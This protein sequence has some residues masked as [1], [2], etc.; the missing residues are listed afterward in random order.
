MGNGNVVKSLAFFLAISIVSIGA[1]E[2]AGA[3]VQVQDEVGNVPASQ[4][5]GLRY[6]VD[7]ARNRVWFLTRDGVFVYEASKPEKVLVQL[8]GWQWVDVEYGCLPDLALGPSGEAIIT[9]NIVPTLWRVDPD[10]LV[11][12]V[13]PLEL[14][15][16]TS[17]DVGFSGL[18]YSSR[19]R[20]FFAVSYVQG[21]F[22]RI[23]PQLKAAQRI[24][25]SAPIPKACGLAVR[26]QIAPPQTIYPGGLCVHT[27]QGDRTIDFVP[28][29]RFAQVRTASCTDRERG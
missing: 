8:P 17:K 25:L 10:T 6:Q 12:S 1:L 9:S 26:A 22:W 16:D 28:G 21:S 7:A 11:V 27:L 14:D 3:R 29:R 15:V 4:P 24:P 18:A 13:H 19:H 5:P 20:A 2:L 23:D